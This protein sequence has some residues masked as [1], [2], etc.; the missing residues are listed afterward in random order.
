MRGQ[1]SSHQQSPPFP[2]PVAQHRASPSAL[3][4][5]C[6]VTRQTFPLAGPCAGQPG[7]ARPR[8]EGAGAPTCAHAAC[9]SHSLQLVSQGALARAPQPGHRCSRFLPSRYPGNRLPLPPANQ[10]AP[11]T[12]RASANGR[13]HHPDPLPG[14][15]ALS[16]ARGPERGGGVSPELLLLES[17]RPTSLENTSWE[18]DSG[19]LAQPLPKTPN[20]LDRFPSGSCPACEHLSG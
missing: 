3:L 9:Q 15:R 14:S 19:P 12:W 20:P 13:P 4:P 7:P 1:P 17:A 10:P 5:A 18:K 2:A 6:P 8:G 16:Q 11:F